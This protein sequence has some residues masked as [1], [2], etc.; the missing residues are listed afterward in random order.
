MKRWVIFSVMLGS[1][2]LLFHGSAAAS[3]MV[4]DVKG[5]SVQD[6][7]AV[8]HWPWKGGPN[9]QWTFKKVGGGWF[10]IVNRNSHMVLDIKG[11]SGQAGAA[12]IQWPWKGAPN[13]QWTFKEVGGGW[14][15]IIGK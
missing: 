15:A 12:L 14:N 2:F 10:A 13:Q 4:L 3:G 5:A 7:A 8:I 1:I 9:Q 6:G 11:G